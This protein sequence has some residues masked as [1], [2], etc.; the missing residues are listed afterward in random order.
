MTELSE[1]LQTTRTAVDAM[2]RTAH[3]SSD[4]WNTPRAAGKW[5]PAQVVEHVALAL[6]ASAAEIAG[7]PTRF[8]TLPRPVRVLVRTL[9]FNRVLR[10][11]TFPKAKTNRA[12]NPHS[13]PATPADAERRLAAACRTLEE[14][15]IGSA[16]AGDLMT[17][18]M[19]GRVRITDY[20]TFQGH[21]TTHHRAQ[22]TWS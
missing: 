12:L 9:F 5:T 15:A 7:R 3:A 2:I 19:F 21:H 16:A 22:M 14:A 8:P 13:G 18:V 1:S 20:V 17:S 10:S 4:R 11:G 6:E